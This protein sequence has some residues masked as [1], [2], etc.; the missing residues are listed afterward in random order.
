MRGLGGWGRITC[1]S[2]YNRYT[3]PKPA[4]PSLSCSCPY[5]CRR[6]PLSVRRGGASRHQNVPKGDVAP[7]SGDPGGA[8]LWV[9]STTEIHFLTHL[10]CFTPS[11]SSFSKRCRADRVACLLQRFL[12]KWCAGD[13]YTHNPFVSLCSPFP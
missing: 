8:N 4:P 7:D 11:N 2:M 3:C 1:R 12:G 9:S 6:D 5:K 13:P 10:S